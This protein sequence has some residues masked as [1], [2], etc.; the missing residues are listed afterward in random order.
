M[1][2]FTP[3]GGSG[4]APLNI[5]GAAN[6]TVANVSIP[7]ANTEVSYI[8]PVNTKKFHISLR[9][10]MATLKLAY[11]LGDSGIT[12]TTVHRGNWY[13]ESDIYLASAITLYF[14]ADVAI[15]TA[16]IVYWI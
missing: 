15:Q 7:L 1:S 3:T 11:V 14:Q 13:S 12:Y 6:P 9:S 8:L 4:G 2:S 16:E 10:G 5:T